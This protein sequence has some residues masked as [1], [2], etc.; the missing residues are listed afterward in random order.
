MCTF[1]LFLHV[2][3]CVIFSG[4]PPALA[5]ARLSHTG[6]SWADRVKCTQAIPSYSQPTTSPVEKQGKKT[7]AAQSGIY[8]LTKCSSFKSTVASSCPR[9]TQYL[10]FTS[11]KKDA[12]GWETVQR[13][14]TA[15]P[16]SAAI[17]AKVSPVLARVT[18]KQD[19][20]KCE[21]AHP[22]PQ[23]QQQ[24]VSSRCP[25]DSHLTK[26]DT[27]Q[28]APTE[29]APQEEVGGQENGPMMEV[30]RFSTL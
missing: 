30:L 15:K 22:S 11:G 6:P 8:F 27:E 14:R 19:N 7:P 17:V 24:Q 1:C 26:T 16:R 20:T 5:A 25:P 3:V 4:P 12:E 9:F 23:E 21:Q 29:P 18:P 10:I 13:G 28:Q 2:Y